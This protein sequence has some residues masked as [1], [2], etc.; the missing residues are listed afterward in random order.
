M[1]LFRLLLLA[2]LAAPL[3]ACETVTP[4]QRRAAD[5]RTCASYGFRPATDPMARCL[6]D[7]D[8]NRHA[9]ARAFQAR[10]DRMMWQPMVVERRV[11]VERR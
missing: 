2:A 10:A 11:I 9:D 5:E 6:L 1:R 4:E 3:C 7:L 8:L